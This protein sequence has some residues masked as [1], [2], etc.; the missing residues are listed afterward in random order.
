MNWLKPGV[1]VRSAAG[2]ERFLMQRSV[3]ANIHFSWSEVLLNLKFHN[4]T[5]KEILHE[6]IQQF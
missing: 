3:Y 5:D 6:V 2:A 1:H 4:W